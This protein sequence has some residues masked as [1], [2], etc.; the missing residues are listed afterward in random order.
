MR[1]LIPAVRDETIV[2][3]LRTLPSSRGEWGVQLELVPPSGRPRA[4]LFT[5]ILD[6][7]GMLIGSHLGTLVWLLRFTR[8]LLLTTLH[9]YCQIAQLAV[10]F[11]DS[12]L[13]VTTNTSVRLSECIWLGLILYN[14][15]HRPPG[16]VGDLISTVHA[17]GAQRSA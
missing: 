9:P 15:V 4:G 12:P 8:F 14:L 13:A 16:S 3:I 11:A 5:N 1:P 6:G 2:S 10:Y 7:L 17:V